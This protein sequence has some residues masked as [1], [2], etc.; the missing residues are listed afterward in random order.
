M[1]N[2]GPQTLQTAT[3]TPTTLRLQVPG[4]AASNVVP[5]VTN[6]SAGTPIRTQLAGNQIVVPVSLA[7]AQVNNSVMPSKAT[8]QTVVGAGSFVPST[9]TPLTVQTT[10]AN[11][12]AASAPSQ[13]SPSTAKKKCKNFLSTLIRLASDQPDN[14]A[15]NV[16]A[17]IQ[18]LI[19]RVINHLLLPCTQLCF[20]FRLF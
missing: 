4:A 5:T 2:V 6:A 15:N 3:P 16:K 19:V 1:V 13:M 9:H 20:Q 14:V 17:L 18:G 11:S 8:A 7:T 12:Q 10:A